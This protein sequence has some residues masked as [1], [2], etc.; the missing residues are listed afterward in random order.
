MCAATVVSGEDTLV[1]PWPGGTVA[2]PDS[3]SAEDEAAYA[4]FY[5]LT[6][7]RVLPT[8][9]LILRDRAAAEDVTQDAFV[10]LYVHW[11]KVSRYEAPESWVRR[12]AIRLAR[13]LAQ[14]ERMREV[15]SRRAHQVPHEVAA[16]DP[17][18]ERAI[19]RLT[20][21]QRA[22]VA[23]FYFEDMSVVEVAST[24]QC[25]QSAV[26]VSLHRARHALALLLDGDGES[27]G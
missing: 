2:R 18:L 23:L 25:S 26:K 21:G 12:V 13:R 9:Y 24:L 8:V 14:R 16:A 15:L 20:P 6:F 11:R 7:P 5:V 4:A 19:A 3:W 17:D 1:R 22:V 27:R 10:Q